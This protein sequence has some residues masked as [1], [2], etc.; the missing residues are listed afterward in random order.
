MAEA[1]VSRRPLEVALPLHLAEPEAHAVRPT[2]AL[3]HCLV[4]G[5]AGRLG[6]PLVRELLRRGARVRGLDVAP[7]ALRH[8]HFEFAPGD[9]C[10]YEDVRKACEGVDTVFHTAAVVD[11]ARFPDR[12]RRERSY[13][14]NVHG[15]EQV[16]RAV[17]DAG[18]ARLV[19]TSSCDVTLDGPV[20]GA[21]ES[22]PTAVRLRDLH[23]ETALLGEQIALAA[24]GRGSLL[25]CA[26]R[27]GQIYGPAGLS[28][29]PR[30]GEAWARGRFPVRLG[31]GG[32]LSDHVFIE[33]LVDAEIEA[34][35]HLLPGSP[36]GGQAYCVNDGAPADTFVRF[37]PVLEALGI[38]PPQRSLPAGAVGHALALWEALHLALGP[39]GLPRPPLLA[40]EATK[41]G[42]SHWHRIDKAERDFGWR[43]RVPPEQ[44]L[45]RMLEPCRRLGA[46]PAHAEPVRP[47]RALLALV[48]AVHRAL[49]VS[50]GGRVGHQ[51]FAYRFLLLGCRGRKTGQEH[52]VPLLY[53]MDGVRFAVV[54]S[55]AGAPRDPAWCTNL[56]ARP[57]GFVQAGRARLA[58]RA[59]EATAAEA[60]RCWPRLLEV[61]PR[62]AAYRER[63]G[64]PIPIVLLERA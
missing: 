22:H 34:A 13:A 23:S 36:L 20:A 48:T 18:V 21:D 42:V 45:A 58:V 8:P 53:V 46:G 52:L 9:V 14:V 56:R 7:L 12:R 28:G 64:R 15:V 51:A 25:T 32:A 1:P 61:Y 60:E 4:T 54:A 38:E 50:T 2:A 11:Y 55:N 57:E 37:R 29:L 16:V 17:Q 47:H 40:R 30:L 62:Y 33:N 5:A 24:S 10:R 3:F 59:R 63:A 31:D 26:I 35:R 49:Y 41:L 27:P 19:H 39:L 44:A 43:P 6:Q